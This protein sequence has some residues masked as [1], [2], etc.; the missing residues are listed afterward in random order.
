MQ[1][2]RPISYELIIKSDNLFAKMICWIKFIV[3]TI[4]QFLFI[5]IMMRNSFCTTILSEENHTLSS[6]LKL[7]VHAKEVLLYIYEI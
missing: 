4:Q 3:F 2:I 5:I 7:N 6:T 1:K